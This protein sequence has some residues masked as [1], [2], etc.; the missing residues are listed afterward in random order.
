MK[1]NV[2]VKEI[3]KTIEYKGITYNLVFNLNVMEEIQIEY[4]TFQKWSDLVMSKGNET[5]IKALLFGLTHMINEGID[6]DN[7]NNNTN[8]EFVTTKKVGRMITDIGLKE[9]T[10]K[11]SKTIIDSTQTNSKNE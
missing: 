5:D 2:N 10:Q 9:V 1:E 6:I 8:I 4:G 11:L 7:E 3:K